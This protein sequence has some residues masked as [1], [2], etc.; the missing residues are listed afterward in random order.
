MNFDGDFDGDLTDGTATF[1]ADRDDYLSERYVPG[2]YEVTISGFAGSVNL[3]SESATFLIRLL[4]PCDAPENIE[5][6]EPL[7][8]QVYIL[9]NAEATP[10]T[11]PDFR[12]VPDF[13]ELD[14]FYTI[15]KLVNASPDTAITRNGKTFSF[16]YLTDLAPLN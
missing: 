2:V 8:N 11:H 6:P 14:Y 13:C 4:D 9:G 12:A 5:V 3:V 16:E 15:T 1:S 7:E 10:Y